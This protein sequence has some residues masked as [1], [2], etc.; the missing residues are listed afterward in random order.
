[1]SQ[2]KKWLHQA[3]WTEKGLKLEMVAL[4][5]VIVAVLAGGIIYHMNNGP[6]VRHDKGLIETA[7]PTPR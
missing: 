1:M 5:A 3:L 4:M 2:I 7:T 6:P